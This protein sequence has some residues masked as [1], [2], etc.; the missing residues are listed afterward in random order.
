MNTNSSNFIKTLIPYII[1]VLLGY[2][3]SNIAFIFLPKYSVEYKLEDNLILKY[4]VF[5]IKHSLD[6][7]KV[8][9]KKVRSKPKKQEYK[10]LANIKLIAIY[11]TT[12]HKGWITIEDNKNITH[13][14][15][16]NDLYRGYKLNKIFN[17]Y[18]IFTKNNQEYKLSLKQ[19]NKNI[20][21]SITKIDKEEKQVEKIIIDDG[22]VT[23]KRD[24]VNKYINNFNK[25]WK[26]ISI[27]EVFKNGKI[28]GFKVTTIRS[29]SVFSKLGLRQGDILKEINNIEL[30]SY[31][32][33]FKIYKKINKINNLHIKILRNN[34]EVEL[35]Y[36]IK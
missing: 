16:Y 13:I 8:V 35:D 34:Q 6:G 19:E 30:K 9:V 7:D 3:F 18:V 5:N 24:Y 23:V 2:L 32:D 1:V 14:L 26:D 25:I 11:A 4:R 36:E 21:Y 31:N 12:N 29:N 27:N 20:N 17:T 10:L 15:S 33:A 28:N 22:K